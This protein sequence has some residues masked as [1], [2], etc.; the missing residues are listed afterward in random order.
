MRLPAKDFSVKVGPFRYD[1]Q[2]SA[3]VMDEASAY[4][5]VH[6]HSQ[7]IFLSPDVP[8]QKQEETFLHEVLHCIHEQTGLRRAL[9][10]EQP[11]ADEDVVAR[12]S[13]A[14]YQVIQDNP[15]IFENGDG[16]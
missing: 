7:R 15:H 1:V 14:L 11:V 10:G 5:S 6:H 2:R 12:T 9:S 16:N 8:R 13:V 3:P 4:G